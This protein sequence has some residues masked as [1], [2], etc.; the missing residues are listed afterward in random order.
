M[1]TFVICIPEL[2]VLILDECP[3]FRLEFSDTCL[4]K[5]VTCVEWLQTGFGLVTVFTEHS[6]M[7]T[8]S[9]SNSSR[10]YTSTRTK[11][12]QSA[13][14]SPMSTAF[15]LTFTTEFLHF[16][17]T[18]QVSK[19]LTPRL[20]AISQQPLTHLSQETLSNWERERERR[21]LGGW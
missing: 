14:Y 8:T 19:H 21:K 11:P 15:V 4:D 20:V 2:P 5:T 18:S 17:F 12:S 13:V 16:W 6:Q 10:I 1:I 3:S 9:N 7:A